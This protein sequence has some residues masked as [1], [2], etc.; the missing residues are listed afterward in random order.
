MKYSECFKSIQGEG[1]L[2]GVPSVFFRLS[3]CNLRC[4][5]CD[6][7]FTS[8]KPENKQ[9]TVDE[10]LAKI[11]SF[12]CKHVVITGGE[13][14]L[15]KKEL[16]DLTNRLRNR[17][18]HVTIETNATIYFPTR[19]NLISMSPKLSSSAPSTQLDQKWAIKHERERINDLA[20]K[21]FLSQK[22]NKDLHW[23]FREDYDYQ[24][25]FVV[26]EESDFNEILDFEKKY[27]IS[28]DRILLMPEG[29][30]KEAIDRKQK[31]LVEF[32]IENGYRFCDR[33]HVRLW[34]EKRG[35]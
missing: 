28:R 30:T 29:T 33:M 6:T 16:I 27:K 2:T 35:V 9:I 7:P 3:Y 32:C 18:Y 8:W 14:F 22:N 21:S 11:L 19:A 24:L 31:P 17:H 4:Y 34:G 12:N 5:F 10:A 25:K 15:W 20:I 13:P 26:A 23:T 1:I